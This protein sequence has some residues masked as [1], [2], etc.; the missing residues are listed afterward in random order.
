[1]ISEDGAL[2]KTEFDAK[3]TGLTANDY[4]SYMFSA[5]ARY[6]RYVGFGSS[7]GTWNSVLELGAI[8]K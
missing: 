8:V 3:S 7:A 4:E 6:I 2:Y 5:K 1:M